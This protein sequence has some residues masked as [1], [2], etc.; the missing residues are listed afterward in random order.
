[1]HLATCCL[2]HH[3]NGDE[4][5][6]ENIVD[7]ITC[8]SKAE[9]LYES[10]ALCI[11]LICCAIGDLCELKVEKPIM[12]GET[13]TAKE[14]E[15]LEEKDVKVGDEEKCQEEEEKEVKEEK[16]EDEEPVSGRGG[17]RDEEQELEELRAQVV[18]LLLELEETREVSQR[19]EESFLEIQ[20]QSFYI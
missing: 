14:R 10:C 7:N 17:E 1:M 9:S 15:S 16:G 5:V 13:L 18:Q 2:N 20:G 8:G 19:H 4:S 3:A 12:L 6:I 11:L